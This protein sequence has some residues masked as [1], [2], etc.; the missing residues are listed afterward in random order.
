MKAS[1]QWSDEIKKF[2]RYSICSRDLIPKWPDP[3]WLDQPLLTTDDAKTFFASDTITACV[4]YDYIYSWVSITLY[5]IFEKRIGIRPMENENQEIAVSVR[6]DNDLKK[7]DFSDIFESE[8]FE[9]TH[10]YIIN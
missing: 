7:P 10:Y 8:P 4:V 6:Y 9:L 1:I 5:G 3:E 2:L